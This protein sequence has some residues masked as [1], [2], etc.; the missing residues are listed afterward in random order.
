MTTQKG[1]PISQCLVLFFILSNTGVLHVIAFT[2]SLHKLKTVWFL[3]HPTCYIEDSLSG[4]QS[5]EYISAGKQ[6][7]RVRNE[8]NNIKSK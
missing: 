1:I 3:A 2:Y 7:S 4:N 5:S 8:G 6:H